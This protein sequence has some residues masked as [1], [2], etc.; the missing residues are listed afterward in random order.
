[1]RL[2]FKHIR[3]T[4]A[5]RP[6]QPLI[7]ILTVM[8]AVITS[9]FAFTVEDTVSR[10]NAAAQ[11][12]SYGGADFT[13]TLSGSSEERF[14]FAAEAEELI[15]AAFDEQLP[16]LLDEDD[17]PAVE[18]SAVEGCYELPLVLEG[19]TALGVAVDFYGID[20]IFSFEFIEYGRVTVG[21]VS[22]T[23][24]I[25]AR[26]AEE[27]GLGLGD[28]IAVELMGGEKKYTVEGI[29][30]TPLIGEHD[31]MVD[32]TGV[33]RM[34]GESSPV[35]AALGDS[36]RPSSTLYVR[37]ARNEDEGIPTYGKKDEK[38]EEIDP[39]LDM[40]ALM[41]EDERYSDKTITDARG[42]ITEKTG[43]GS[44]DT[45][46]AF[47]VALACL[48][49][50]VVTFCCFYILAS[51]RVEENLSL[52]YAGASPR[53]L[54]GIQYA[55]AFIYWLIGAPLGAL[56]SIPLARVATSFIGLKYSTF[57]VSV[58]TLIK[59]SL[60]ILPVSL[61]TVAFFIVTG[62]K[63]RR[64]GNAHTVRWRG[65][66]ISLG[67]AG[68]IML[69]M[70]LLPPKLKFAA[71]IGVTALTVTAV[72][73]II[74]PI[75]RAIASRIERSGSVSLRYALKNLSSVRIMHNIS[76]IV[77]LSLMITLVTC[78]VFASIGGI[79]DIVS[80]IIDADYAVINATDRCSEA[81]LECSEAE[82]VYK[83]FIADGPSTQLIAAD[84]LSVFS[85]KLGIDE[86][87]VGE[88]AVVGSGFA[89]MN[90]IKVGDRFT[91]KISGVERELIAGSINRSGISYVAFDAE[92]LGI[93]YNMLLVKG[94]EDVSRTELLDGLSAATASELGAV[95][96]ADTLLRGIEDT[97]R[98]Y[99]NMGKM[100]IMVFAVFSLIGIADILLESTRARREEFHLYSLAGMEKGRTRRMRRLE[101]AASLLLGIALSIIASLLLSVALDMGMQT[102]GY[103]VFASIF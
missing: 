9:V 3:R 95:V 11:E 67:A 57:E 70:A 68:A 81:V 79:T 19:E 16:A 98:L 78:V 56:V 46:V 90:G 60:V 44:L 85:D 28:E 75:I 20:R 4:V 26:L 61:L 64:T 33:R 43:T 65:S 88:R 77:A 69:A 6:T 54:S 103:E 101:V 5:K 49:S 66:L 24:F 45:L 89:N 102:F 82:R 38:G 83:A 84:D 92:G 13:V 34:M 73:L 8:L 100:L 36:F 10:E 23:A 1:M 41:A 76:R 94:R 35:F 18:P 25:S 91:V 39:V 12:A 2:I 21:S 15:R 32:I 62:K 93:S 74:P 14:M 80:D 99:L 7:L 37:L 59:S 71:F 30:R 53:V 63:Q 58:V 86:K 87:P 29:T 72:F 22:D 97:S 42:I 27:R 17:K 50:A 52:A 47:A 48:L 55:E 96:S 31:I 51:E 40:M